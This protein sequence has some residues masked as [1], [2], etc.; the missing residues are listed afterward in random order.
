MKFFQAKWSLNGGMTNNTWYDEDHRA[1]YKI[2]TPFK[3][4]NRTSTIIKLLG[5]DIEENPFAEELGDAE[6]QIEGASSSEMK[7]TCRDS[8]GARSTTSSI[9]PDKINN[10]KWEED[11]VVEPEPLA[12]SPGSFSRYH[13]AAGD[14]FIYLAQI[15][16]QVF[17]SSKIR[18]GDGQE[19]LTQEFFR[20]VGWG[21]YGRHRVFTGKDGKEYKW[22]LLWFHSELVTND[23]KKTV[24]AKFAQ[25]SF[26]VKKSSPGLLEIFPPGEHMVDEIFTTF[27]YIEKLRKE[28][29]NGSKY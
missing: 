16:W 22:L 18:F 23:E 10:G 27:I 5:Q 24:V 17:A 15:D 19:V 28:K 7:P 14:R 26:F 11:V 20:K 4:A 1:V 6:A 21:P 9:D 8:S 25:K 13:Q 2:H 3:F 29:E 12:L